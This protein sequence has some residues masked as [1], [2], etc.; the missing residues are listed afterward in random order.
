MSDDTLRVLQ[1]KDIFS[2]MRKIMDK[3]DFSQQLIALPLWHLYLDG[4]QPSYFK[5]IDSE[6]YKYFKKYYSIELH[7]V[8]FYLEIYDD[9]IQ[10][11]ELRYMSLGSEQAELNILSLVPQSMSMKMVHHLVNPYDL[12]AGN[13][14]APEERSYFTA[15]FL[16]KGRK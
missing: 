2:R 7:P 10:K 12:Y 11:Q 5:G 9:E 14:A 15:V 16:I 13:E 1:N 3:H 8:V 6:F 4:L